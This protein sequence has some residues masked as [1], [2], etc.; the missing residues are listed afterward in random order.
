MYNP[1]TNSF[2]FSNALLW[3]DFVVALLVLVGFGVLVVFLFKR[4]ITYIIYSVNALVT[5]VAWFFGLKLIM[6]LSLVMLSVALVT[7]FSVNVASIRP[8]ISDSLA[9]KN[10][11]LPF[12]PVNINPSNY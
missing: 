7:F 9:G 8:Y 1:L 5:L 4:K 11:S 10:I 12:L 2:D 3:V 6:Y